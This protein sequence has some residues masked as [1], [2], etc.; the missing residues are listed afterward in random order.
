MEHFSNKPLAGLVD[1]HV[2]S[3]ASD[4]TDAPAEIVRQ[5]FS[6]GLEAIA[7]TDHDC[8]DGVP[9]AQ[10]EAEKTGLEL[11][12]GCELSTYTPYGEMHIVSLWLDRENSR[13]KALLARQIAM[14][15]ERN[16]E[17]LDMLRKVGIDI[18]YSELE[19]DGGSVGRPHIALALIKRGFA[20]SV[21]EVFKN[22][23]VPGKPGFVPRKLLE[24]EEVLAEMKGCGAITV[25][26]HPMS[27][28]APKSWLE[29]KV[30]S[31]AGSGLLDGL[32]AYHPEHNSAKIAYVEE[33][34][35]KHNLLL[36]GGSDYHGLVKPK[37]RLG[38]GDGRIRVPVELLDLMKERRAV[39]NL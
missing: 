35:G 32:E 31:L 25:F 18:S 11:I 36:S 8:M 16:H 34:A 24:P 1:L 38:V 7:L 17:I 12:P 26:A 20:R 9:E 39:G 6:L 30:E 14:R 13:V 28:P 23:M 10:A 29:E 4:G 5:A 37:I 33:L 27:L 15:E 2:H 3:T 19:S 22:F 21:S